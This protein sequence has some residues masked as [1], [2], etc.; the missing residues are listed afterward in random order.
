MAEESLNSEDD[1]IHPSSYEQLRE[2]ICMSNPRDVT[3]SRSGVDVEKAEADFSEQNRLFSSISHQARRLSRQASHASKPTGTD[4][5]VERAASSADSD[6]DWE[7]ETALR[8]NRAAEEEA[9]IR[10]K[11]IGELTSFSGFISAD[12]LYQ[13]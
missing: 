7:L 5:D 9:G 13:V 1:S 11:H 8:G 10:D 2:E 6:D 12:I 3:S 4:E